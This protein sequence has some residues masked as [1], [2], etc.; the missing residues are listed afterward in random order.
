MGQV[1]LVYALSY[2]VVRFAIRIRA[3]RS[4]RRYLWIDVTDRSFDFSDDQFGCGHWCGSL[5]VYSLATCEYN[6]GCESSCNFKRT[7]IEVAQTSVCVSH[8]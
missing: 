2:S 7:G 1:I 8:S 6:G 4:P 5:V 3:R